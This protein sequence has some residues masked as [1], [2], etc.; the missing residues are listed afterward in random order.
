MTTR[1]SPIELSKP[2][3]QWEPLLQI[4]IQAERAPVR[5]V[6][7]R[8]CSP[9][10]LPGTATRP[11]H[12]LRHAV[13]LW[14]VIGLISGATLGQ[15]SGGNPAV[16]S[17]D[18]APSPLEKVGSV[19]SMSFIIGN[20]GVVAPITGQSHEE[21]MGF[22]IEL[23]QCVPNPAN[24]KA[25]SGSALS[26]FDVSYN[27]DLNRI[28]ARQKAGVLLDVTTLQTLIISAIVTQAS[29]SSDDNSIGA[30]CRILPNTRSLPTQS[31][32]D[33][34]ISI[35]TH[36]T[37]NALEGSQV[38]FSAQDQ[39]DRTVRLKWSMNVERAIKAFIIE[40]SKDSK[41]FEIVD[42]VTDGGKS[43]NPKRQYQLVDKSPYRGTSYYRLRLV[44]SDG[45][46]H[47]YPAVAPVVLEGQYGVDSKL[48]VG[49]SFMLNLDEPQ[50]AV[51]HL[52]TANGKE[53]TL[54]RSEATESSVRLRASDKLDRGVYLLSV[55]ERGTTRQ[56]RLVVR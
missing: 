8:R 12:Y 42:Q 17:G 41:Q 38:S 51:L 9:G 26:V 36:T 29:A 7:C 25:L 22:Y 32:D 19:F 54:N 40:R 48:V 4:D 10:T 46:E 11:S 21:R 2:A 30:R 16:T 33:D 44:E 52:Y 20:N 28:E 49:Q 1:T 6:T 53:I 27:A 14:L 15:G 31:Q 35:Y 13:L 50:T 18:L 3:T 47:S 37:V 56:H 5:K 23:N 24:E 39:S 34:V 43:N 55:E 45:S